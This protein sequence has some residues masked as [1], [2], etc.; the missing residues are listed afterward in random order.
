M[1]REYFRLTELPFSIAPDPRFLYMSERH[2]EALAHLLYGLQG[3][4]GFV[5]LTG[6]VGTGKTT[7]CRCLL[8]QVPAHCDVAFILNPKMNGLELL[9]SICDEFRIPYPAGNA[10]IKIFV[11]A[12]NRFLLARNAAGRKAVLIIDEAQNL[13]PEVLEQLR[14]LTNLETHTRKLLQIVLLG[15]PELLAL[16]ARPDLRQVAQRVTA[17]Y[18]LDTLT[19]LE[20]A[21]YVAHR[22]RVSG[23]ASPLIPEPLIR[24]LYR[25]TGG[26][27]RLINL[28]CDRALLGAYVEGKPRVDRRVLRKAA[29][30][31]FGA[32]PARRGFSW[33]W[34]G[35]AALLL[36]GVAGWAAWPLL[37]W[38]APARP[39]GTAGTAAA[40]PPAAAAQ[41]VPPA[42][43][44]PPVLA[45]PE[46]VPAERSEEI[47]Y[48][49]LFTLLD[50]AFPPQERG[51]PCRYAASVGLRCLPGQGGLAE[52]RQIDQPALVRLESGGQR[53][54]AV[55][56]GASGDDV[57]LVVADRS[58][59]LPLAE[60]PR[61][62]GGDYVVLWQ[63]PSGY[64]RVLREG[65]RSPAVAWVRQRLGAPAA[66]PGE[67]DVYDAEL[68]SR[69]TAFQQ[70]EGLASD[71]LIGPATLIRLRLQ[72]EPGRVR[73]ARAAA[74]GA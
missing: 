36:A 53:F 64:D 58:L 33:A 57:R 54:S 43:V 28:V 50:V 19:R 20:A 73:L 74:D 65:E 16:L 1:Y 14:L 52:L 59:S 55:M 24:P 37:P 35:A 62:W 8:E 67:A 51:D 30:E 41:A 7:L 40:P 39:A 22:L 31:V 34:S 4:G 29:A 45:W 9:A 44:A 5:L 2:R 13:A 26:V 15:Q 32:R 6:E 46:K 18:H 47:A 66:R 17:R 27:P 71:G 12:L 25:A 63:P 56:V 60:L 21:A 48:L 11:D 42:P 61:V 70:A 23:A 38:Q 10:S 69:V 72:N 68:L 49:Q 3:E